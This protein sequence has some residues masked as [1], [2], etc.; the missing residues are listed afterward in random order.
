MNTQRKKILYVITKSNFGGAQRYVFE[1][2]TM[3]PKD[4]FDITVAFGGSGKLKQ[5]LEEA[6]IK[7]RTIQSFERDINFLKEVRAMFELKDI[8]RDIQPDI[9]HLNS[10]KAGG[11]GALIARILGVPKIIF[12]A[13][14]W[15]FL[16]QRSFLWRKTVLFLSWTTGLLV[17]TLIVVSENDFRHT[18]VP[19]LKKK[20]V[21]IQTGVDHII[22]FN[23]ETARRMF[24]SENE[25]H[26]HTH[27]LWMVTIAELT[28]N[29]NILTAIQAVAKYNSDNPARK[30]LYAICG[31]GEQRELC[32]EYLTKHNLRDQIKLLGY[33]DNARIYLQGFDVFLLP[34]LK[35]GLP[36]ALLEAGS[37]GLTVI[38]SN[39]GGIPEIITHGETGLLIDSRSVTSIQESL[40]YITRNGASTMQDRLTEKITA[41]F[42]IK[43]M[44]NATKKIY[45]S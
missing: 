5:K 2:A 40:E 20:C 7:T 12:T 1:L 22:F 6:G 9:I 10:S 29:K 34:S 24:F 38:A 3:L 15:P 27:D 8:V 42:G 44:V 23:R 35:E 13:H 19:F 17:H 43:E 39:V 4:L 33:V 41:S 16:E 37:A 21:V 32:E 36:Y 25:I 11:T 31:D 14:G 30:I 28:P 45:I 18:P 26:E